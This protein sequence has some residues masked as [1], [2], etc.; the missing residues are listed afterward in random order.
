M[1]QRLFIST[2]PSQ[3]PAS[4]GAGVGGRHRKDLD[5]ERPD[6]PEGDNWPQGRNRKQRDRVC[7]C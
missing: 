7:P 4:P 2:G 6:R 1:P 5:Q 3:L